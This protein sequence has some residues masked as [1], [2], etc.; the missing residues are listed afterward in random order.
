MITEIGNP[1]MD[2]YVSSEEANEYFLNRSHG[3]AW[4]DI[5]DIEPF[6]ITATNQID[7]FMSFSGYKKDSEQPLEWPR[8]EVFDKKNQ[9]LVASDIIPRKI[10]QAVLELAFS[11]IESDRTADSDMIGLQKVKVGT[12]EVVANSSGSWQ[13]KKSTIPSIIYKILDGLILDYGSSSMFKQT[14]RM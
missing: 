2:S 3:D 10:K 5:D 4:E 12:L 6:L 14:V 11:N 8:K 13:E 7:W 9:S 1:D